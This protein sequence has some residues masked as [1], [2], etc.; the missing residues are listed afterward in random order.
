MYGVLKVQK[1]QSPKVQK[2]VSPWNLRLPALK[3][4]KTIA[5]GQS[6]SRKKVQKSKSLKV[7][8]QRL[9]LRLLDSETFGL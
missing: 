8:E 9:T 4:R 5:N 6:P 2:W 7:Q 1:S 3:G